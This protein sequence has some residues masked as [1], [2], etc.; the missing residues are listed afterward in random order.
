MSR[1]PSDTDGSPGPLRRLRRTVRRYW[2]DAKSVYYANTPIWRFLKSAALFVFGLFCWVGANLLLSYQPTWG[3]LWYVM[4]YGFVLLL[5]GPL[6]HFVVVPFVI[7]LRRTASGPVARALSRHGSKL[8]LTTFFLIVLVLGTYP[9]GPMTFD[10]QLPGG[11]DPQPDVDPDLSCEKTDELVAC[12][13]SD[14]TGI[15]RVVVT[16]DA[17]DTLVVDDEPPFAFEFRIADVETVR[18]QQTFTVD[19][20]D[21][22]ER[23]LRRYT[24][25]I[26][27]VPEA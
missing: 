13:L 24:Q 1:R 27:R 18:G 25:T 8:N 17:G 20:Q 10:F 11:D 7:R 19:L 9:I 23:T 12:E 4:S 16:D 15:D 26:E 5:W 22:D 3:F 2:R 21:E 6:T 14:S